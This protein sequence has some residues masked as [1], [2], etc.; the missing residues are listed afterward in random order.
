MLFIIIYYLQPC[1]SATP[2]ALDG[3]AVNIYEMAVNLW[4]LWPK[5]KINHICLI[6]FL[7]PPMLVKQSVHL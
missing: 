7:S 6:C 4:I 1:T 2:A 5:P 3:P